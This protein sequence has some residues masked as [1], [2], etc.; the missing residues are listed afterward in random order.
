MTDAEYFSPKYKDYISNSK[1]ALIN[2]DQGGSPELYNTGFQ[3]GFS[4][5]FELGSAVHGLLLQPDEFEIPTLNKPTGK[6][7]VFAE[8]VYK[9]RQEGKTIQESFD[10]AKVEADYYQKSFSIKRQQTA[11]KKSLDFYIGRMKFKEDPIK[12]PLFLSKPNAD[13][14]AL[15]I[16]NVEKDKS[17]MSYLR[18]TGLLEDPEIFNEYAILCELKLT[19]DETGE[20]KFIKAK[21]KIDNFTIDHEQRLIILNDLKTTGRPLDWFMGSYV[22]RGPDIGKEWMEGSF[23]KYHYYRQAAFYLWLLRSYLNEGHPDFTYKVNFLVVE[24]IPNF[25]CKVFTIQ[26]EWVQLGLKEVKKLLILAANEYESK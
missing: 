3:G 21:A 6:L 25:N 8:A 20:I 17:M 4:D 2:P 23:E 9:F 10:L 7:G 24:T 14:C 16:E 19:D 13:K 26:N 18:P 11:I 22:D 15:C 1:L 12:V 5:S